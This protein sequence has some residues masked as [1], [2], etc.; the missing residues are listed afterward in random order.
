MVWFGLG[1]GEGSAECD[2]QRQSYIE[3]HDG[4][5][6]ESL[7]CSPSEL[8]QGE[9]ISDGKGGHEVEERVGFHRFVW[10]LS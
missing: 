2:T 5:N 10:G 6:C 1:L 9:D 8:G 7:A 4:D 3:S